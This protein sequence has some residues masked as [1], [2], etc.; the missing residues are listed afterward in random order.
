MNKTVQ[1]HLIPKHYDNLTNKVGDIIKVGDHYA[2]AGREDLGNEAFSLILT[3]DDEIKL[4]PA[5]DKISV[6]L[7]ISWT[8]SK[9]EVFNAN[10]WQNGYYVDYST[11]KNFNDNL[12]KQIIAGT[13]IPGVLSISTDDVSWITESGLP[14]TLDIVVEPESEM[15]LIK[16]GGCVMFAW[17]AVEA[18][19]KQ[20]SER[21]KFDKQYFP[22]FK[23][24]YDFCK[25]EM[26]SDTEAFFEWIGKNKVDFDQKANLW[27]MP[28]VLAEDFGEC[29]KTT[30]ELYEIFKKDIAFRA[31]MNQHARPA[32]S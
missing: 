7:L 13:D 21:L 15:P 10:W 9:K 1:V 5:K 26:L 14:T 27:F 20:Q 19:L 23:A 2:I 16:S 12:C 32:K 24:G 17:S 18:R 11:G 4:H 8:D 25:E 3:T 28:V 6:P 29:F 30:A 31:K 22:V